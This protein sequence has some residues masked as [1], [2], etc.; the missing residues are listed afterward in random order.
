M[1]E[2][3]IFN[4]NE[5]SVKIIPEIKKPKK[6]KKIVVKETVEKKECAFCNFVKKNYKLAYLPAVLSVVAIF[7]SFFVKI[8][9]IVSFTASSIFFF[10]GFGCVFAGLIIEAICMIKEKKFEFNMKVLLICLAFFVLFI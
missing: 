5:E 4:N 6:E 10:I 3:E 2:Y 1:S 8:L 9:P 7:F